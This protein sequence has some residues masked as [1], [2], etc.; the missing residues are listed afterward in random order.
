[1]TGEGSYEVDVTSVTVRPKE[2]AEHGINK[3]TETTLS[4]VWSLTMVVTHLHTTQGYHICTGFVFHYALRNALN[5]V[6]VSYV[7]TVFR[8]YH[9]VVASSTRDNVVGIAT[10]HLVDLLEQQVPVSAFKPNCRSNEAGATVVNGY[11]VP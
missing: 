6:V 8:W 3:Q 9:V 5:R 1:M 11:K 10:E 2:R 4:T 7:D